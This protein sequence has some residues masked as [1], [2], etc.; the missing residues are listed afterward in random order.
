MWKGRCNILTFL[1]VSHDG[2][3][4]GLPDGVDLA[5][6]SAA[7]DADPDVDLG[8]PVLAEQQN[9]LLQFEL[10]RL[11]LNLIQRLA[12]DPEDALSALAISHGGRGLFAAENLHGLN[13]LL[14]VGGHLKK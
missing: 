5:H 8:E 10:Q 14:V 6:T 9:G 12:V 11:G 13:R 2:L 4:Q 3:G 1:V 7:L